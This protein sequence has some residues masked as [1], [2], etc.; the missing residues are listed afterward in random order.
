MDLLKY[1][2]EKAMMSYIHILHSASYIFLAS[3]FHLNGNSMLEML[4]KVKLFMI[5][6]NNL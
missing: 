6:Q 4:K 2:I 5:R 1:V 3:F